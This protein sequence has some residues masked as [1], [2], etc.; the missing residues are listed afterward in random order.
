MDKPS[1]S[2][3][4]STPLL[5]QISQN[6]DEHIAVY[7]T[8][9]YVTCGGLVAMA[10]Y[11]IRRHQWFTV[12]QSP[13]QLLSLA[14]DNAVWLRISLPEAASTTSTATSTT[15]HHFQLYAQHVPKAVVYCLPSSSYDKYLGP[16]IAVKPLALLPTD[17][18]EIAN[19]IGVLALA[20]STANNMVKA[21]AF[22]ADE[23]FCECRLKIKLSWWR[24]QDLSS[25]VLA[26]GCCAMDH[27]TYLTL[28]SGKSDDYWTNVLDGLKA[29]EQE[30]IR[31]RRGRWKFGSGNEG[32]KTLTE[33]KMQFMEW[34]SR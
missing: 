19:T 6:I 34:I 7:R 32:G 29:T 26:Q 25:L 22:S 2:T 27:E 10:M 24:S 4:T 23:N 9:A 15:N 31:K 16:R 20:L 1:T 33:R 21:R 11:R 30:A 5:D 3:S 18:T 28:P 12:A 17:G 8:M 14:S 13:Q